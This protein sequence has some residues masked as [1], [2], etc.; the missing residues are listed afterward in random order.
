[1]DPKFLETKKVE[2]KDSKKEKIQIVV[3]AVLGLVLTFLIFKTF[4]AGPSKPPKPASPAPQ[5]AV[6]PVP[7]AQVP[8]KQAALP[9]GPRT[10][11]DWGASPFSLK[12]VEEP[13]SSKPRPVLELQGIVIDHDNAYAIINE[14][15]VKKG[16]TLADNTVIDI[17]LD[18]VILENENG[19]TVRLEE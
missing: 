18:A 1:M 10:E 6:S 16:D 15:I 8:L 11:D 2:K 3:L 13:L 9:K 12:K 19:E 17:E 5:V 4:F 7:Q 14:K